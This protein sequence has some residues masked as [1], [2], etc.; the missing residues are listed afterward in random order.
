MRHT[1]RTC[2]LHE[3]LVLPHLSRL[4]FSLHSRKNNAYRGANT[5]PSTT[6]DW[7]RAWTRFPRRRVHTVVRHSEVQRE[8]RSLESAELR[9]SS[10]LLRLR[11][12]PPLPW[13]PEPKH[14]KG[15]RLSL[16]GVVPSSSRL[17][18][19]SGSTRPATADV[20]MWRSVI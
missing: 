13:L 5:A 8:S 6:R 11:Q 18:R 15:H 12:F 3:V 17:P 9:I 4:W 16:S 1:C 7:R 14:V 2:T 20:S 10:T 19:A